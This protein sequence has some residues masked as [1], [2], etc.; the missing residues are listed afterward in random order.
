MGNSSTILEEHCSEDIPKTSG[1]L[2]THGLFVFWS[3]LPSTYNNSSTLP[4]LC[5]SNLFL[6]VCFLQV[7][8]DQMKVFIQQEFKKVQKV[9]A[10]EEQKALHLVDIQE[11][12]AT[13]HVTEIL[14]DIQSHMDRLMTQMAQAKE[15]LDTSNESAEPKAEVKENAYNN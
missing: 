15:Q 8:R 7:T 3:G 12:M 4:F 14:A 13:A 2:R 10:D 5:V 1:F 11:A 9:I 6:I